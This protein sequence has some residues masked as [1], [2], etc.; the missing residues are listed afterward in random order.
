MIITSGK[1]MKFAQEKVSTKVKKG[2]K[3][4]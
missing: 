3:N 1:A 4:E 2:K